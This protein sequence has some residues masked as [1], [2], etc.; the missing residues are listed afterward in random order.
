MTW[1]Y[2]VFREANGDYTIREVFYDDNGQITASTAT[3]VEPMGESLEAL[4]QDLEWFKA[5]LNLPVLTLEDI[6][7]PQVNFERYCDRT[8]NISHKQLLQQLGLDN[9][10]RT[11]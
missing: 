1:N 3:P 6:P 9:P 7:Q 2:R 11:L 10:A 8:H 5:A 4:A